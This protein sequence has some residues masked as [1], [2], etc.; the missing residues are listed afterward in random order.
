MTGPSDSADHPVGNVWHASEH[1]ARARLQARRSRT[2]RYCTGCAYPGSL[3][4]AIKPGDVY[5]HY[6]LFPR[7]DVWQNEVPWALNECADCARRYGRGHLIDQR[8]ARR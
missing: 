7:N 5:V 6:V 3:T 4:R 2:Y 1:E 8:E